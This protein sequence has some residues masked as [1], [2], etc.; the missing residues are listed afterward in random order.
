MYLN[1]YNLNA[2]PFEPTV[3]PEFIWFGVQHR[4]ALAML[5]YGILENKG[6]LLLTG[7]V[8]V[9]KTTL[10]SALVGE[11]SDAVV[12]AIVSDPGVPVMDF[13]RILARGLGLNDDFNRK[14][15]FLKLFQS[16][17]Y[18][19]QDKGKGVLLVIDEAQRMGVE[20]LDDVRLLSNMERHGKKLLHVFFVG[21]TE[22]LNTL[23]NQ[24]ARALRQR[25]TVSF[26]IAPLSL[27]ETYR[28]I[29]A[30]LKKAGAKTNCFTEAAIEEIYAYS[31]GAP[32]MINAVCDMAMVVGYSKGVVRLEK[33]TVRDG[34]VNIPGVVAP[35]KKAVMGDDDAVVVSPEKI[36]S[37]F[38]EETSLPLSPSRKLSGP[39][40]WGLGLFMILAFF[41]GMS[42]FALSG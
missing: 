28:Y 36:G 35:V 29:A 19:T 33:Q 17:L 8:G 23:E 15:D 11:L 32:R 21:Q 27:R 16:F 38:S 13:F 4:E 6:L 24:D 14:S 9:G 2:K 22:F 12:C 41:L 7:D 10:I 31:G 20:L 18:D 3:D 39:F 37:S 5:R 34:A 25:I 40:R 30:R 42:W 26:S 1:H